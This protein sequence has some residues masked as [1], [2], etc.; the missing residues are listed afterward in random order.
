MKAST[1]Q[2][3]QEESLLLVLEQIRCNKT[4]LH[5]C[6]EICFDEI[7]LHKLHKEFRTLIEKSTRCGAGEPVVAPMLLEH[8]CWGWFLNPAIGIL[9]ENIDC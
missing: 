2:A 3:L 5:F 1:S 6:M 7:F 8:G 9:T 4:I